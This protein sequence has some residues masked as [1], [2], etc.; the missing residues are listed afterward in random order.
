MRIFKSSFKY[1]FLKIHPLDLI[2]NSS[3][4]QVDRIPDEISQTYSIKTKIKNQSINSSI[5]RQKQNQLIIVLSNLERRSL[6]QRH[7]NSII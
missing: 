3:I 5:K 6:F 7:L 1:Y 2:F 4:Q